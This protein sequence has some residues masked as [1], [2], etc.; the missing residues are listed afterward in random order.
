M[1]S[2]SVPFDER[3]QARTCLWQCCLG[4]VEYLR[5][6]YM[7][8]FCSNG[9]L[10]LQLRY[11][12][13]ATA[14]CKIRLCTEVRICAHMHERVQTHAASRFQP[15]DRKQAWAQLRSPADVHRIGKSRPVWSVN[16]DKAYSGF[17][18]EFGVISLDVRTSLSLISG[19]PCTRDKWHLRCF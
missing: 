18:L 1:K 4:R 11:R 14:C 3:S 5:L 9:Q 10:A 2:T 12:P 7:S 8:V 15:G 19:A 16:V 6:P 17:R 13:E